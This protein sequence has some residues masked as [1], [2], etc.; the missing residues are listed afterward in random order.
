MKKNKR[1]LEVIKTKKITSLIIISYEILGLIFCILFFKQFKDMPIYSKALPVGTIIIFI[2]IA[3]QILLISNSK[4]KDLIYTKPI[5]CIIED[6]I[7]ITYYNDGV[8]Y[9]VYPVVKSL[10]DNKLYFTY[11]NYCLVGYNTIYAQMNKSLLFK[12]IYRKDKSKVKIGDEAYVYIRRNLDLN[13]DINY[14]K[15]IVRLNKKK[16]HYKHENDKYNINVFNN[17]H[18]FEGFIDIEKNT[19]NI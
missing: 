13:I 4:L 3:T 12:T 8:E 15:N 16:I 6:F 2:L 7:Y 1:V 11:G 10:E 17:L 18:Y 5:K 9:H 19:D 14:E